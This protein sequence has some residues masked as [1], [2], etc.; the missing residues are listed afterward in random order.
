MKFEVENI[1]AVRGH[2]Y[3]LARQITQGAW[4]L[5]D[6]AQ[7]NEVFI[8]KWV[9]VPRALDAN[10]E[11]RPGLYAFVLRDPSHSSAFSVGQIVE[12]AP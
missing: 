6:K 5:S 7:L 9:D 11:Q 2:A 4:Q 3:V 1:L 10:E 12:L 8:H